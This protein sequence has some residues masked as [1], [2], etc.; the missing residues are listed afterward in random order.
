MRTT[1]LRRLGAAAVATALA[2]GVA[3][4]PVQA[5]VNDKFYTTAPAVD[6]FAGLDFV[7]TNQVLFDAR[8]VKCAL[9]YEVTSYPSESATV[10]L[11]S[12]TET[13]LTLRASEVGDYGITVYCAQ[14][15]KIDRGFELIDLRDPH[16]GD[17]LTTYY[18]VHNLSSANGGV[19]LNDQ[20]YTLSQ[21]GSDATLQEPIVAPNSSTA[22]KIYSV[23]SPASGPDAQCSID[24]ATGR[25][26]FLAIGTCV[27]TVIIPS[28]G[29]HGQISDTAIVTV[30]NPYIYTVTVYGWVQKSGSD[31]NNKS[32]SAAR[33]KAV[34]AY[35]KG[36]GLDADRF[37]AVGKGVK[38]QSSKAR[39][40]YV[41]VSW[42]GPTTGRKAT[43]VYF[44]VNSHKLSKKTKSSLR[45]LWSRV[46]R[47]V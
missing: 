14:Y 10:T 25:L 35:L 41:V 38:G 36:L 9:T 23:A 39:S 30:V 19:L 32:L 12:V 27:V 13:E 22:D 37:V 21:S 8:G 42:T 44:S 2:L 47:P 17:I 15:G 4:A 1:S 46:P 18:T 7:L 26:T 24:S 43:T 28:D 20:Q 5:Q 16:G 3:G 34:R 40:A 6:A 33:A 11:Q 45:V 29:V 31:R